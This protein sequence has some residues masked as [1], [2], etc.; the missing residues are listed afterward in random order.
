[1]IV[2]FERRVIEMPVAVGGASQASRAAERRA[3]APIV[4]IRTESATETRTFKLIGSAVALAIMFY[5][6]VIYLSRGRLIF[7]PK[8]QTIFGLTA[9]DDRAAV[10]AKVGEPA[11]D[12]WQS[13]A[14]T[15]QYEALEY[16]GRRITVI[17]MGGSRNR[18]FYIGAMD[19]KWKP[20]ASVWL[21]SGGSSES[22]LHTLKPF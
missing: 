18:V 2:P 7:T 3:P 8:D 22:I 16:P 19:D 13:D 6:A 15:N 17:L 11:S 9:R 14:E 12:R 21:G 10:V 4:G 1:M 20:V 5:L